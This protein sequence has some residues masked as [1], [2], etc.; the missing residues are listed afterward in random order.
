MTRI[1]YRF[2]IHHQPPYFVKA[3]DMMGRL[4]MM[5]NVYLNDTVEFSSE[6]DRPIAK[7]KDDLKGVF[8]SLGHKVAKVEGGKIE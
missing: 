2:N 8:E 5:C 7:I 3:C 4:D 1:K 6:F